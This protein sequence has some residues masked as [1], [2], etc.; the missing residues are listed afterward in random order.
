MSSL[1]RKRTEPEDSDSEDDNDA[2]NLPP[3]SPQRQYPPS[4]PPAF[5]DD[6]EVRD[7]VRDEEDDLEGLE[8]LAAEMEGED[9]FGDDMFR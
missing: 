2:R 1:R 6:S 8:D 9:L 3:S 5:F 4:S 7:E